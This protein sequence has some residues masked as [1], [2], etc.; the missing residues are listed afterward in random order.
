MSKKIQ[1]NNTYLSRAYDILGAVLGAR[2]MKTNMFPFFQGLRVQE[3]ECSELYFR[4]V[5]DVNVYD[6]PKEDD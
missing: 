6:A 2:N 3:V 4:N 5:I 1:F